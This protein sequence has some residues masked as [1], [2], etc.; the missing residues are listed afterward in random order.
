M[1]QLFQTALLFPTDKF[2]SL[3]FFIPQT[4]ISFREGAAHKN[5][6][7]GSFVLDISQLL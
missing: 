5:Y 3:H 6:S 2:S 7:S 1:L 4:E